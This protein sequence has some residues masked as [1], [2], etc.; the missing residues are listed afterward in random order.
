MTGILFLIG[1]L[2]LGANP[3]P[4]ATQSG[5]DRLLRALQPVLPPGIKTPEHRFSESALALAFPIPRQAGRLAARTLE[6][7]RT[8]LTELRKTLE[9]QGKTA[10]TGALHRQ[11][12]LRHMDVGDCRALLTQLAIDLERGARKLPEEVGSGRLRTALA[13][14]ELLRTSRSNLTAMARTLRLAAEAA[15][16]ARRTLVRML[17]RLEKIQDESGAP[18]RERVL[19]EAQPG[20]VAPLTRALEGLE[21]LLTQPDK[22]LE[23]MRSLRKVRFLGLQET[24]RNLSSGSTASTRKVQDLAPVAE[25]LK[26]LHQ[27]LLKQLTDVSHRIEALETGRKVIPPL[28]PLPDWIFTQTGASLFP[29]PAEEAS[30]GSVEALAL[31]D[32]IEKELDQD[33]VL[34]ENPLTATLAE[35]F[36][37]RH[38]WELD[39]HPE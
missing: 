18:D 9:G 32:E 14:E 31:L 34:Y 27:K 29:E 12:E 35:S 28:P 5:S 13:L 33:T 2:F 38:S 8:R 24:L 11:L 7:T 21:K 16:S 6:T 37:D 30:V 3:L 26:A 1:A 4:A 23:R 10:T 15:A 20:S 25:D 22:G 19:V 17:G 36:R 39:F